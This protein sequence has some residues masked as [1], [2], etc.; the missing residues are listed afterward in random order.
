MYK[1]VTFAWPIQYL[2]QFIL[3]TITKIK[4]YRKLAQ[5][6]KH[7]KKKFQQYVIVVSKFVSQL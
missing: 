5:K 2:V 1:Y 6:K 7:C 4:M 3:F